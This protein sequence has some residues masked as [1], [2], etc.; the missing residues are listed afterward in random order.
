M[1]VDRYG[2]QKEESLLLVW[3]GPL[4]STITFENLE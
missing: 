4:S 2:T 3:C 1:K